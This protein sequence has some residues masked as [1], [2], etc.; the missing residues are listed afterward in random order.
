MSERVPP[1]I[2][3]WLLR[4][5]GSRYHAESLAGD[6]IEQY[7]EGRSRAWYWRQVAVAVSVA[8]SHAV[9]ASASAACRLLAR[10]IAE[11]AAVL[12]IVVVVDRARGAHSLAGTMNMTFV[13]VLA[14]LITAAGIG[15][16]ISTRPSKHGRMHAL[17]N[18]A[19]L[20]FGVI[21]LGAGTLTWAGTLRADR[22]QAAARICPTIG[23]SSIDQS[24]VGRP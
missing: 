20:A 1:K 24:L 6:L 15:Y 7:R 9:R 13:A 3:A 21:A 18:A 10:L 4:K 8:Q 22:C 12:S 19:V 2:A 23:H 14:G 16:L 11:T 5:W 17:L